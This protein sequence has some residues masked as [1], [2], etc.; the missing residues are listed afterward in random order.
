MPA[1]GRRGR[2]SHRIRGTTMRA[3]RLRNLLEKVALPYPSIQ[4]FDGSASR[5][6]NCINDLT[7]PKRPSIPLSQRMQA[8]ERSNNILDEAL[9]LSGV[10]I[11]H[12][13]TVFRAGGE[14]SH[15]VLEERP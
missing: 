10:V 6:L 9:Q 4:C 11:L 15:L 14:A 13:K 7:G 8:L 5:C 1:S 3:L 12:Y 2:R